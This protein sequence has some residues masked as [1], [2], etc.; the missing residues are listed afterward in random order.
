MTLNGDVMTKLVVLIG[1]CV[2]FAAGLTVGVS[3]E[4][5]LQ[6]AASVATTMPTTRPNHRG[7]FLPSEL[8]LTPQQQEAFSKIWSDT[9]RGGRSEQDERRHQLLQTRDETIA[10]LISPDIKEKYEQALKDYTDQ[11]AAMDKEMRD[12]FKKAV[13]E[14]NALLTPEQRTKY[15]EI[16]SRHP[17]AGPNGPGGPFGRGRG[18]NG[19]H[20]GQH[21]GSHDGK[22]DHDT[23]RR[24]DPAQ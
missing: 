2:A 16:L 8:N 6:R 23:T 18:G 22:P 9:A 17:F 20:D 21:D 7:G 1:F 13:D 10:S 24:S 3:H 15:E 14:T 12:R 19:P 4:R 5:Q 11:M